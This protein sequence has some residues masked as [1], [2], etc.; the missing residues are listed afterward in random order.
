MPVRSLSS[1]VFKWPNAQEVAQ[2]VRQWAHCASQQRNEVQR[3]GYL[4]SYA[5]GDWGVGSDLDL[6]IVVDFCDEPFERRAS[7]W[8]TTALPVPAD[9]L[10]YTNQEWQR[11]C[12][13]RRF[14]ETLMR[15][16]IWVYVKPNLI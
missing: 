1:S 16:T 5:R 11:L 15:E 8:D 7:S 4:G 9:V 6:V 14:Y 2:A 13:Q 3:I 12:Q 10:I